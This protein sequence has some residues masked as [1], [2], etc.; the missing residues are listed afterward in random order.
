MR[1]KIILCLW[2]S[3]VP[4]NWGGRIIGWGLHLEN[5]F[6]NWGVRNDWGCQ[7]SDV[8]KKIKIVI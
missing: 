6:N 7:F 1:L 4:N 5:L 8:S 2:Y 3:I